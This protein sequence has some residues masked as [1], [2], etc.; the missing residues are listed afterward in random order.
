[1]AKVLYTSPSLQLLWILEKQFPLFKV[2]RVVDTQPAMSPFH[3]NWKALKDK[4]PYT[5]E[6]YYGEIEKLPHLPGGRR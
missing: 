5:P 4:Y 6:R 1:M 2:P 3:K